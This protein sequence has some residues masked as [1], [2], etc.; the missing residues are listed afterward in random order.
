MSARPGSF[1]LRG[2]ITA[3][4]GAYLTQRTHAEVGGMLDIDPSTVSRRGADLR[5]WPF[6]DGLSMAVRDRDLGE[7]VVAYLQGDPESEG[8]PTRAVPDLFEVL[9]RCGDLVRDAAAMV[10]DG[11]VDRGE[12]R[13]ALLKLRDARDLFGRAERNLRPIAGLEGTP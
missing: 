5:A 4:L 13:R 7:A 1:A 12:A 9:E 3:S 10:A 2:R 6:A 11:K 8:Q